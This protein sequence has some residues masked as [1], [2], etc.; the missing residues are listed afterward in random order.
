MRF[1][2][3]RTEEPEAQSDAVA[4]AEEA[5]FEPTEE[6]RAEVHEQTERAVERTRRGFFSRLGGIFERPDF[7]DTLWD[8]LEEVLIGADAGLE[9]TTTILDAVRRRVKA[10]GAKQSARVREI[11]RE[12]LV[13]V[14]HEPR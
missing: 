7:D 10:E 5:H 3:K 4:V 8:E 14:L 12:E 6:E 1:W 9:T 2:R 11:L 13:A